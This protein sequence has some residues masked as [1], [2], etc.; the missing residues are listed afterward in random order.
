MRIVAADGEVVWDLQSTPVS[1]LEAFLLNIVDHKFRQRLRCEGDDC[2]ALRLHHLERF[3]ERSCTVTT[4]V[5]VPF[6]T[7]R[8]LRRASDSR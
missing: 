6:S 7:V 1:D 8:P 2:D 3:D 4:G 5:F